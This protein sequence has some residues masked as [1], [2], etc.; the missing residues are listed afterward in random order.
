MY[1]KLPSVAS[2]CDRTGVADR[3]AA[4]IT[5]LQDVYTISDEKRSTEIEI[6]K[7]RRVGIKNRKWYVENIVKLVQKISKNIKK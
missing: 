4:T 5:A 3:I 2:A 6:L 7:I 1:M